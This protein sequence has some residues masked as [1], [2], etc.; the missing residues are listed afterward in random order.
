[1]RGRLAG[2]TNW[3]RMT[4][5]GVVFL[6][7]SPALSPS[8]GRQG[9]CASVATLVFDYVACAADPDLSVHRGGN[10]D[11]G[12]KLAGRDPAT[13]V[14]ECV[15]VWGGG[16]T[17]GGRVGGS[18]RQARS[19]HDPPAATG[20]ARVACWGSDAGPP[21]GR[22]R[23]PPQPPTDDDSRHVWFQKRCPG[24]GPSAHRALDRPGLDACPRP[25]RRSQVSIVM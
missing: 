3:V 20:V 4:S 14:C 18:A 1:M 15:L 11:W 5:P 6:L 12:V 22:A 8:K 19:G 17:K 16:R 23:I 2:D 10:W 7:A 24:W 9:F 25:P 21:E 13:A